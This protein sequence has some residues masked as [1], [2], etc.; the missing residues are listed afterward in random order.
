MEKQTESCR[1]LIIGSGP[2]G[3]S[4]AIYSAR[5]GLHPIVLTGETLGGQAS[6]TSEVE[7]YPGFPEVISGME[8]LER[9]QKQAERLGTV[10]EYDI[11]E[12]VDFSKAPFV[13][14]TGEKLF[15][16]E[17]VI[18]TAGSKHLPLNVPGEKKLI[19]KGISYCAT[20]DG[21]FFRG[22]KVVVVGGGNSAVEEAIFL[23]RYA[24]SV[25]V[26]HRRDSLRADQ[27]LQDKAFSNEKISFIWNSTVTEVIGTERVSAVMLK[28]VKTGSERQLNTDGV[29][30]FVGTRATIDL[31]EGQV[32]TEKGVIKVD[33]HMQTSVPGVFAAGESVDA[34]YRQIITS[35]G[36]GAQA[37]ISATKYLE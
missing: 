16:A 7:N 21:A 25:T 4:A 6:Q 28:N 27:I 19:G 22:K 30:V 18:I 1:V 15:Q 2:A 13:V 36:S 32:E 11:A 24:A 29:F 9:F 26:I 10:I 31:F 23:T 20:C 35:A 33:A 14:E 3:L 37:G 34:I 5:A 8:L 12:R 17:T